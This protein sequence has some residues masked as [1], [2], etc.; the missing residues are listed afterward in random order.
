MSGNRAPALAAI[1]ALLSAGVT[2]GDDRPPTSPNTLLLALDGVGHHHLVQARA[3]GAFAGWPEPRPLVSTFPSMTNIGFVAI[4]S[5]L[6]PSPMPGYEVRHFDHRENRIVGGSPIGLKK[7]LGAWR[8]LF[9]ASTTSLWGKA[10]IHLWPKA[11]ARRELDRIEKLV[12]EHPQE[13]MLGLVSS[14]DTLAHVD[15]DEATIRLLLDVSARVDRL[16]SEHAARHGRPLRVIVLSDHGNGGGK[17]RAAGGIRRVLEEAGLRPTDRLLG[18]T[19]IVVVSYG[20]CGYGSLFL[21]RE[22][23]ETAAAAVLGHEGVELAAWIS[24]EGE[25]RVRGR[26][27]EALVRWR[28]AAPFRRMTYE[29][30]IG[31]PLRLAGPR[32]ELER[33]GRLDDDGFAYESDWFEVSGAGDYPD[34]LTRLVD[35]LAGRFV[36]NAA[37]V[38]FSYAPGYALG[39]RTARAGAWLL[40]GKL[41]ATHGGLD[42][43][44]TWGIYLRSDDDGRAGVPIRADAALA[45]W[46]DAPELRAALEAQLH[47]SRLHRPRILR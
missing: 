38:L 23:A 19:D 20:V 35:G 41:E 13:R 8:G 21:A 31:D 37:T 1:I 6:E 27:G 43:E 15:G 16:R 28:G 17:V 29:P 12:L 22:R 7:Q 47:A 25:L 46:A 18:P 9:D 39:I 4:L 33:A 34:A 44:S 32:S 14:S 30:R 2:V 45:E 40:G 3:R 42:R 11:G 24:A 10:F 26:D 5:P 36:N